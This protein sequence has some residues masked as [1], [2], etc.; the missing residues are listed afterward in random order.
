MK[1]RIGIGAGLGL[2]LNP[3]QGVGLSIDQSRVLAHA[4]RG[5]SWKDP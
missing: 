5:K 4:Q 1:E 2:D 3:G